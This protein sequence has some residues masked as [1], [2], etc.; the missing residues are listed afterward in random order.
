MPDRL[1]GA[2]ALGVVGHFD[3]GER[4]AVL[5]ELAAR[6][7]VGAVAL[8][9]L[10]EPARP[11]RV[12]PYEFTVATVGEITYRGIADAWPIDLEAMRWR[13]TY[14]SLEGERVL[15]EETIDHVY[16]HPAPERFAA[17]AQDAGFEVH[18]VAGSPFRILQRR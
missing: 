17:E 4:V 8:V 2:I 13:T 9:D 6:T 10:Q 15:T 1:G 12:D 14:L 16:R 18:A 3:A 7:V 5:A 11:A